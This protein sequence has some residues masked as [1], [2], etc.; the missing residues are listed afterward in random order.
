MVSCRRSNTSSAA[1]AEPEEL[2]APGEEGEKAAP[3]PPPPLEGEV[4]VRFHPAN[5]ALTC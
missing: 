1:E 2:G 5:E 4:C 3:P